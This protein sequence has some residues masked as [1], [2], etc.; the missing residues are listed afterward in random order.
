MY[1]VDQLLLAGHMDSSQHGTRHLAELI[2]D[3][4][5][6]GAVCW[7]EYKDEPLAARSPSSPASLWR[8]RGMVV[9]QQPDLVVLRIAPSNVFRKAMKS[10]LLYVS[11]AKYEIGMNSGAF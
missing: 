5:Q 2:L 6:P 11:V 3:Q 1:S 10:L 4:I 9:K 7:C 8:V